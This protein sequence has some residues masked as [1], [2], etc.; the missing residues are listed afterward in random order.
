MHKQR[1][2]RNELEKMK[3]G[4][5]VGS[6]SVE[7]KTLRASLIPI[8]QRTLE[9]VGIAYLQTLQHAIQPL[10]ICCLL[11][12]VRGHWTCDTQQQ[13]TWG[14]YGIPDGGHHSAVQL[15]LCVSLS[16]DQDSAV[17]A[18]QRELS[19]LPQ[20]LAGA[21]QH[22]AR[23]AYRARHVYGLPGKNTVDHFIGYIKNVF[24]SLVSDSSSLHLSVND[25]YSIVPLG[26]HSFQVLDMHIHERIHWRHC[27]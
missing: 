24:C 20:Q 16:T 3:I 4:N 6:L 19:G 27:V 14:S 1:E 25:E 26:S 12:A 18:R 7:S 15:S 5:V 13:S 10:L 17:E 22:P 2:W 23:A 9:Q 8:T 21:D 11:W